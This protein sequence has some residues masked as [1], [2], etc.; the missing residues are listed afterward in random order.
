ML[1]RTGVPP[2]TVHEQKRRRDEVQNLYARRMPHGSNPFARHAVTNKKITPLGGAGTPLEG[3]S[4]DSQFY[5]DKNA[6][7]MSVMKNGIKKNYRSTDMSSRF[8]N[9]RQTDRR[10][11]STRIVE[12]EIN[13][14]DH[15]R[16][17][18]P[19][20]RIMGNDKRTGPKSFRS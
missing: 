10:L 15:N 14:I 3:L 20:T 2:K 7:L 12:E 18:S 13:Y 8:P 9:S 6:H 4:V 16:K 5:G 17:M 19:L 1:N 11:Q